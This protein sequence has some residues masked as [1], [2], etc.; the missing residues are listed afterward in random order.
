MMMSKLNPLFI[1][2]LSLFLFLFIFLSLL[3]R[4]PIGAK[5]DS[6]NISILWIVHLVLVIIFISMA[7]CI[8]Y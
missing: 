6:V 2:Q 3:L 7:I 8:V 1:L 5:L 4:S